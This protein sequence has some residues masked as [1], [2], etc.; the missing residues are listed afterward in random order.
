MLQTSIFGNKKAKFGLAE[1]TRD[2]MICLKE[3]IESKKLKVVIDKR[4]SLNQIA[5]AHI[6]SEKGHARGKI[7]ITI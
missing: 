5:E 2:D 7:A 1:L 3:L 6:Y 4:Y